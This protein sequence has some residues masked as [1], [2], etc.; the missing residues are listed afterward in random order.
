MNGVEQIFRANQS[1]DLLK[2]ELEK[3][4]QENGY[5]MQQLVQPDRPDQFI[6]GFEWIDHYMCE[7]KYGSCQRISVSKENKDRCIG[8]SMIEI[9]F[10][11]FAFFHTHP[12]TLKGKIS[13]KMAG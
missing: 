8:G 10:P 9:Y 7:E 12:G 13:Y 5:H 2:S 3:Q 1:T 11:T 4:D 6:A